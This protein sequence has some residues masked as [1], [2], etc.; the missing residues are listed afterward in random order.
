MEWDGMGCGWDW[1]SAVD[2]PLLV[3]LF[4]AASCD[5]FIN[6]FRRY[7]AFLRCLRC[8]PLFLVFVNF[9]LR[10]LELREGFLLSVSAHS[11]VA[12]ICYLIV[13]YSFFLGGFFFLSPSLSLSRGFWFRNRRVLVLFWKLLVFVCLFVLLFFLLLRF[14]VWLSLE[15]RLL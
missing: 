7:R 8:F 11:S 3:A 12:A 6:A 13:V 10:I 14:C 5:S 15:L 9:L 2:F 1:I 4:F